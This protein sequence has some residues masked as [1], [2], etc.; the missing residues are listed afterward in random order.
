VTHSTQQIVPGRPVTHPGP[1][2]EDRITAVRGRT[3]PHLIT[4]LPTATSDHRHGAGLLTDAVIAAVEAAGADSGIVEFSTL[5]LPHISYCFPAAGD[6]VH[7]MLYSET[8]TSTGTV[9][10]GT[11][12]V[13]WR[14]RPVEAG[15][16]PTGDLERWVHF[17]ASWVDDA[18]ALRGGHLWPETA[19]AG[20]LERATVWPLH[21]IT[22]INDFDEETEL[23]VFT[24]VRA[25]AV[26]AAP[27]SPGDRDAVF[28]RVRPNAE[29]HEIVRGLTAAHSLAGGAVHGGTGSL[30]GAVFDDG[31]VVDGPATEVI[32]LAGRLDDSAVGPLTCTLIT[33][34][35]TVES[36]RL[37][38]AGNIVGA[39]YD[40]L[41]TGPPAAPNA[42]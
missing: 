3:R 32:S 27:T 15:G 6:A 16:E 36:G 9:L 28:A 13:G 8:H 41:L 22:L 23:P 25:E 19:T 18:G 30:V 33:A 34:R 42:S 38:A 31:R 40:L 1:V 20:A 11:A 39:T 35:G 29:I 21:G 17:H 2:A 26:A 4:D 14:R 37:A 10:E 7:P 24:P 5:R 12:T